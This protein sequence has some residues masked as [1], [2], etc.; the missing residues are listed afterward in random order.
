MAD[1]VHITGFDAAALKALAAAIN[2][3]SHTLP[4]GTPYNGR[5]TGLPG[6][7]NKDPIKATARS[8]G[9]L[10]DETGDLEDSFN[11]LGA[12]LKKVKKQLGS[13]V[14]AGGAGTGASSR[15]A[16]PAKPAKIPKIKDSG[17]KDLSRD[18]EEAGDTVSK[19]SSLLSNKFQRIAMEGGGLGYALHSLS[20]LIEG[21]VI[22]I[23]SDV[24]KLQRR[25]IAAQ[26]NLLDFYIAAGKAGMSLD[27]YIKL[28]ED[29]TVAVARSKSFADFNHRLEATTEQLAGLG[30]FGAAARTMTATMMSSATTLGVPQA[31]LGSVVTDQIKTFKQLRDVTGMTAAGFQQLVSDFSKMEEAQGLLLGMA[32]D[33]RE[34][35]RKD[36]FNSYTLGQQMGLTADA[37]QRLG[38][39][40]LAQR[41]MTAVDRFKAQGTIRQAGAIVGMGAGE[42]EELA[43]LGLKKNRSKEENARFVELGGRMQAG[44]ETMQNSGNLAAENIADQLGTAFPGGLGEQLKAAGEAK[45]TTDSGEVNKNFSASTGKFGQFVGQFGTYIEGLVKSPLYDVLKSVGGIMLGLAAFKV[46]G[47]GSIVAAVVEGVKGAFGFG[48]KG[49]IVKGLAGAL[50]V[51]AK[52]TA[53]VGAA[54]A[55]AGTAALQALGVAAGELTSTLGAQGVAA[56][57]L[58]S[59]LGAQ[60]PKIIKAGDAVAEAKLSPKAPNLTT[61]LGANGAGGPGKMPN[62][63]TTLGADPVEKIKYAKGSA[64]DLVDQAPD[65]STSGKPQATAEATVKKSTGRI[66]KTMQ[67]LSEAIKRSSSTVVEAGRSAGSAIMS[68]VKGAGAVGAVAAEVSEKA[69]VAA[70]GEGAETAAKAGTKTIGK[71]V[72]RA[73]L[74]QLSRF[75]LVSFI[76]GAIEEVFTGDI[77]AATGSVEKEAIEFG[78]SGWAVRL[79]SMLFSKIGDMTVAG[80][81]MI[82]TSLLGLGDFVLTAFGLDDLFG[83]SLVNIFDR[84]FSFLLAGWEGIKSFL[85]DKAGS[86][87]KAMGL[88]S[89]GGWFGKKAEEAENAQ[90]TNFDNITKLSKDGSATLSSIGDNNQKT[91]EAQKKGAEAAAKAT[92][93]STKQLQNNVVMGLD[94]LV[95]SAQSTVQQAQAN[96]QTQA[97]AQQAQ[98][99]KQVT[100]VIATPGPTD[101]AGVTQPDVNKPQVEEKKEKPVVSGGNAVDNMAA[102]LVVLQQQLEIAKQQLAAMSGKKEEP[103][104]QLSRPPLPSTADLTSAVYA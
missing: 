58:T 66:S 49:G 45:L 73:L 37:S 72:G 50:G 46:L 82:A 86:L 78:K 10:G 81:R 94:S 44:L 2:N 20:Q 91:L 92:A 93:G 80:V 12:A 21:P 22:Q 1:Q 39:A 69:L 74:G 31:Q 19:S 87:F 60:G 96:M 43:K 24:F 42:T 67:M 100:P 53:A 68:S 38:A 104:I 55:T 99:A 6:A 4:A 32:P 98:P 33:Q 36:L 48:G 34:Q 8:M 75:P 70:A 52:S 40:L 88:T 97:A 51:G 102:V 56:G 79:G 41:K 14:T 26:G 16:K 83:V 28:I 76:F 77:G 63:S 84:A 15:G 57:E 7:N 101:R 64:I 59:T 47:G 25:G 54:S 11:E 23:F 5:K 85:Y 62:W 18:F 89:L 65:W 35:A 13:L 17:V 9:K 29:N 103:A 27:E 90:T 61:S 3:A 71:T 95:S 30:V